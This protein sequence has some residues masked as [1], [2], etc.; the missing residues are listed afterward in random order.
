MRNPPS[1]PGASGSSAAKK[2]ART[3]PSPRRARSCD[4]QP[5]EVARERPGRAEEA[6]GDNRDGERQDGRVLGRAR[7]Q[8]AG[9][10]HQADT[11]GDRSARRARRPAGSPPRCAGEREQRSSALVTP[12]S[13]SAGDSARRQAHHAVG[14]ARELASCVISKHG[15]ACRALST[16]SATSRALS[17]RGRRW[18]RRG[19]AAGRRAANARAS[20]MRRRSP[21]RKPAA[22]VADDGRVAVGQ[23][24]R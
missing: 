15:P 13:R 23:G 7:D 8:I 16:A 19:S 18:A 20:A 22:A 2:R 5:L 3:R 14:V 17:R 10:R 6:H 11:A 21:A 1:R 12:P 9:R 24:A 4:G